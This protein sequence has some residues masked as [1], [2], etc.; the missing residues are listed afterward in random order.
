MENKK[1]KIVILTGSGISAESGLTTFRDAGGLWEEYNVEEVCT[2]KAW[3]ENPEK[4]V[5]F[6]NMVRQ[7]VYM[8]QP[9]AAHLAITKLQN[10]FPDLEII[11]QNVDNLHEKAGSKNIL[12]LHG[13]INKLRST[14]NPDAELIDCYGNEVYGDKHPDGSKLRPHI[15]FFGEDVP[16]MIPAKEIVKTADIFIVIGTSLQVYPA[17]SLLEHVPW[18]SE[19][20]IVDP[21]EFEPF[22]NSYLEHIQENATSGVPKLVDRLIEKYRI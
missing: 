7:K 11:T 20:Y 10:T 3:D 15:V 2:K 16:N 12:H 4:L 5:N 9:N 18:E 13:E 22:S 17:A 19:I 14:K 6:Y 21:G 1:P 8:A